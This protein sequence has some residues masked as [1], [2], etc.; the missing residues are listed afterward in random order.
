VNSP[1]Q[2]ISDLADAFDVLGSNPQLKQS[3][4]KAALS[5]AESQTWQHRAEAMNELYAE[6]MSGEPG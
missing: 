5:F 4:S 3:M 6:T 2:A 1:Q